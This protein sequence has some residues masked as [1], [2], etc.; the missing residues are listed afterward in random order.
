MHKTSS[1]LDRQEEKE[2]ITTKIKGRVPSPYDAM[3]TSVRQGRL[4]NDHS[5]RRK[6]QTT[7]VCSDLLFSG[8]AH[9]HRC[10]VG[11]IWPPDSRLSS[12]TSP[13]KQTSKDR[14]N[15]N[16]THCGPSRPWG[17]THMPPALWSVCT[18]PDGGA[19]L[20]LQA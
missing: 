9:N 6:C 14:A 13:C 16:T 10:P 3:V 4:S 8:I 5:G 20:K 17:L 12:M 18:S 2:Q 19:S 7:I 15:Q 1:V 11:W